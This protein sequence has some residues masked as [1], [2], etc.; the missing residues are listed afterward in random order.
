M[1][2]EEAAA[3]QPELPA[4]GQDQEPFAE[5]SVEDFDEVM[6]E[7]MV[8]NGPPAQGRHTDADEDEDA[9][10]F[11]HEDDFHQDLYSEKRNLKHEQRRSASAQESA[12]PFRSAASAAAGHQLGALRK[13]LSSAKFVMNDEPAH[14]EDVLQRVEQIRAAITR[15]KLLRE[16]FQGPPGLETMLE[17]EDERVRRFTLMVC[18]YATELKDFCHR[19]DRGDARKDEI[20]RRNYEEQKAGKKRRDRQDEARINTHG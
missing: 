7:A 15:E 5:F 3:D 18:R 12:E 19:S 4:Y 9:S 20:Q 2:P 11:G 8:Q 10:Q 16:I 13:V 17:E 14:R 6:G 1:Q